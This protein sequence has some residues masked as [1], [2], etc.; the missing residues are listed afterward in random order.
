MSL[1]IAQYLAWRYIRG[2]YNNTSISTLTKV[3][4]LGITISTLSLTI[5]LFIMDGFDKALTQKMQSIYPQLMLEAPQENSFEF[6]A[7]KNLLNK[8]YPGA[9][10]ACAPVH[11]KRI[12]IQSS[13]SSTASAVYFKAI[14]PLQENNV[15]SLQEKLLYSHSLITALEKNK[16]IIGT[17]LADF[18]DVRIGDTITILFSAE[19]EFD[20]KNLNFKS[21]TVTVGE[22]LKT[23]IIQ[24]DKYLLI[25]SHDLMKTI[26]GEDL[27]TEIGIRLSPHINETEFAQT[28]EKDFKT[29]VNSWKTLYPALVSAAKLEKYVMFF[30]LALIVL[31]ATTNLIALLFIQIT[32]K[33]TDIALLQTLGMSKKS[34]INIFVFMGFFITLFATLCGLIG[35]YAIGWVLQTYPFI[36]LPD[37]YYVSTLPICMNYVTIGIVLIITLSISLII[38]F[39]TA[40]TAQSISITNTLR[41]DG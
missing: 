39:L 32:H 10:Q 8:N 36:H 17:T 27:V 15:S 28:L 20:T 19:D 35:A 6:N 23:G 31:I 3:C 40:R 16:V 22:I 26:T 38:T 21:M 4:F 41:F 9:I 30:L 12:V 14:D 37:S 5:E 13:G 29:E 2:S 33:R 11:T 25:G 18:L 24:Y 1:K 7:I 34:I